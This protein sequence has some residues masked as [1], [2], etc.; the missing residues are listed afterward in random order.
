MARD[1][2]GSSD[3]LEATV[4]QGIPLSFGCHYYVAAAN[5]ADTIMAVDTS[6]AQGHMVRMY[7]TAAG[8]VV[9]NSVQSPVQKDF[10]TTGV[11]NTG[12]WE[13]ALVVVH[14]ATERYLYSSTAARGG[15]SSEP[16]I[17]P[18]DMNRVVLGAMN[19]GAPKIQHLDGSVA[20]AAVWNGALSQAS[21][22]AFVAG[23]HPLLIEPEILKEFWPIY[24]HT[25]PEI[26]L[27]GA[28]TM[29]VTGSTEVAS[30]LCPLQ[31]PWMVNYTPPG[32][33]DGDGGG[34]HSPIINGG[35]A[36][37]TGL[38][39][40]RIIRPDTIRGAVEEAA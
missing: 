40:G 4:S 36:F 26:G 5:F 24:G 32:A 18:S 27:L 29:A 22:E 8:G 30:P 37:A 33:A 2:D 15:S 11:L 39:G 6:G 21:A 38:F 1:L 16:S 34:A 13:I 9:V 35:S 23:A 31:E 3:F 28:G 7:T 25:A 10:T 19:W 12:S 20:W 14:S 17:S